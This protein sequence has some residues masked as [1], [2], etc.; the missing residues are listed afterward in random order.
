MV[1]PLKI[2]DPNT[3]CDTVSSIKSP[4]IRFYFLFF[5]FHIEYNTKLILKCS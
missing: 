5:Q 1:T 3:V 4:D 2:K